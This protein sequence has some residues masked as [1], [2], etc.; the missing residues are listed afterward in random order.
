MSELVCTY[1]LNMQPAPAGFALFGC[2][3]G[4]LVGVDI[5]GL[6]VSAEAPVR[7]SRCFQEPH[8]HSNDRDVAR[9]RLRQRATPFSTTEA[10]GHSISG[11]MYIRRGC[12]VS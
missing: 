10:I 2:I 9:P 12:F 6:V 4:I 7:L 3:Y 11:F 5:T 1:A 8:N